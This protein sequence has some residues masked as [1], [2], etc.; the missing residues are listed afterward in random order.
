MPGVDPAPALWS[1]GDWDAVARTMAPIHD[2]LVEALSPKPGERWLDVATGT[3]AI[4]L[5]GAR[6]GAEVTGIDITPDLIEIARKHAV[7]ERLAIQ[8]DVG[9]AQELPYEDAR[10]DVV[11]SAH[12]V[13]F[14]PDHAR[15]VAELARV[16]R[17]G[18]RLGITVWRSGGA[19]DEFAEMVARYEPP[20]TRARRGTFGEPDYATKLLGE[21][22]ELE[23]IPEVWMQTGSSGEEIWSLMTRSAPH[24]KRLVES[25]DPARYEDFRRDWI[26][27]YERY[28]DGDV[29]RAPNEYMLILGRRRR[30]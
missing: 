2:R 13:H 3:G 18:G 14:A 23:F 1:S 17:P 11:S 16:C 22:F 5:R 6:A 27:Y 9:N 12:G 7:D 25:L 21:A 24:L 4:A 26:E 20:P 19:V 8:F 30:P 29:V 28:R 10:F 15:A